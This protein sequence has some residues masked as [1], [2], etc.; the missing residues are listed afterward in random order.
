VLIGVPLFPGSSFDSTASCRV[1]SSLIS[2]PDKL[3]RQQADAVADAL[4]M[5][6]RR[7][8]HPPVPSWYRSAES[9]RLTPEVE[10][11]LYRQVRGN[12]G[13]NRA[14][15]LIFLPILF[16]VF[17]R[18]A[19]PGM[20]QVFYLTVSLIGFAA[21]LVLMMYTRRQLARRAR[22]LASQSQP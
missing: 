4:L 9:R 5:E 1:Q 3:T 10:W 15:A 21:W 18:F 22:E 11:E 19:P 20:R 7:R 8:E 17:F 12:V 13:A 14:R 6:H 2:T 16:I